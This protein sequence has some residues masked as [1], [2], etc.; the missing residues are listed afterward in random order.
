MKYFHGYPC[1]EERRAG[2]PSSKGNGNF[3]AN[4]SK[5]FLVQFDGPGINLCSS[6]YNFYWRNRD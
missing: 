2:T 5:T 6:P 3:L 1:E 4:S